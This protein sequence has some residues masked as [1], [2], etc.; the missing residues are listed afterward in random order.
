MIS[1]RN[2]IPGKY[3]KAVFPDKNTYLC[4][5]KTDT[6]VEAFF[7]N[8]SPKKASGNIHGA[9]ITEVSETYA[10]S[11]GLTVDNNHEAKHLLDSDY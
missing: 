3:Y 4:R 1:S 5:A 11:G 8:G 7:L 10:R 9:S 2:L 6:T